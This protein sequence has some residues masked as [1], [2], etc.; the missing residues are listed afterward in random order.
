MTKLPSKFQPDYQ[1]EFFLNL[2]RIL[3]P[4]GG[5]KFEC[6]G[7]ELAFYIAH[8]YGSHLDLLHIGTDP[9]ENIEGYLE[10]L[11]KFE[12]EHDLVIKKGKNPPKAIIDYWRDKKHNLVIMSGRR[13]PT[14]L[15]K[16]F[17]PSISSSVIPHIDAEVLQVFPPMM[18]KDSEKLKNIA[19]LLPYSHRDPFLLRWSS[20]I[21]A[22]QKGA[23]VKVYHIAQVPASV[24]LTGAAKEE[25]I[26]NLI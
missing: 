11:A 12:I 22:P 26:Q 19:V 2:D 1:D 5:K 18:Q 8:E 4:I 24:P 17:V 10:K 16:I 20:A 15:D 25:V 3:V 21:A 6:T 23:K 9:G 13:R 7:L 14:L